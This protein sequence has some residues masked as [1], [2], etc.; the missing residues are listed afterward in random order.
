LLVFETFSTITLLILVIFAKQD[1]HSELKEL[2]PEQQVCVT[3]F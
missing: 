1:L 2:I 3:N